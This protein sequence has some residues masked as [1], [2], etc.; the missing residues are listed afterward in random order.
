MGQVPNT[1]VEETNLPVVQQQAPSTQ[2]F[3]QTRVAD[4]K[5]RADNAVHRARQAD[6]RIQALRNSIIAEGEQVGLSETISAALVM[7]NHQ[8]GLAAKQVER[9][10][11]W[12]RKAVRRCQMFDNNGDYVSLVKAIRYAHVAERAAAL[13]EN[14][15]YFAEYYHV[16]RNRYQLV[17]KGP[18]DES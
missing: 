2:T 1:P 13:A 17:D 18:D 15:A 10:E 9:A 8:R 7:V 11:R 14:Q 4:A 3:E 5:A 16:D 12:H 6:S